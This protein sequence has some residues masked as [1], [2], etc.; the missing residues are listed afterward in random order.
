MLNT[1]RNIEIVRKYLRTYPFKNPD[2]WL[3]SEGFIKT[4]EGGI[5]PLD[6]GKA[7][8]KEM[9]PSAMTYINNNPLSPELLKRLRGYLIRLIKEN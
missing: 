3:L 2:Y 9:L 1:Q 5:V 7:A 4:L 8:I 6:Y